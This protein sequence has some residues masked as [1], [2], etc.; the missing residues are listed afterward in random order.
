MNGLE[1]LEKGFW[2]LTHKGNINYYNIIENELR[3]FNIII[4]AFLD[5]EEREELCKMSIEEIEKSYSSADEKIQRMFNKED[6]IYVLTV[7]R[8]MC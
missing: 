5:E 3:A 6:Y 1:A 2:K 4:K 8:G 7:L